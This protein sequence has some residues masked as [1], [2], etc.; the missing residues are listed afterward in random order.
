[1][2]Q[3]CYVINQNYIGQFK[4]SALS[5]LLNTKEVVQFHIIKSNLT[6]EDQKDIMRFLE[7]YDSSVAFY[8]LCDDLFK[9]LPKMSYDQTYTAYY[10]IFIPNVLSDLDR[11]LYL[12]ADIIVN[13]DIAN[14]YNIDTNQKF[15]SCV[16]DPKINQTK[17]DHVLKFNHQENT[18]FNSGVL[19]FDFKY[20]SCMK[21]EEQIK[22]FIQDHLSFIIYHD[23]DILN[24]LYHTDVQL[25]PETYNYSSMP[26]KISDFL[27]PKKPKDIII[28]YMNWKPWNAN[29]MGKYRKLYKKYYRMIEKKENLHFFKRKNIFSC[30][31]L[32]FKYLF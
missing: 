13:G 25:L 32:I 18:Y 21:S 4:V 14:L 24:G 5:L 11:V 8:S 17:K 29:Y 9:G 28:H 10:K 27:F 22:A 23:Q 26:K 31:K 3:I 7:R 6:V 1:M 15:L 20:K 19:L 30:L 16:L 2:I 12:D